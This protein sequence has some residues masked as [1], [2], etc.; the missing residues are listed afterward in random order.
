VSLL[1]NDFAKS[2][3]PL[4]SSPLLVYGPSLASPCMTALA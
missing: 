2:T 1:L 4:V 3:T